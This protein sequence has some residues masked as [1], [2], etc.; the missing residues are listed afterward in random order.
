[1]TTT[2]TPPRVGRGRIVAFAVVAVLAVAGGGAYVLRNAQESQQEQT[3]AAASEAARPKLDEDAVLGVPHLVF[4][5][6]ALGPSYGKIGLVPLSDPKGPR[7]TDRGVVTKYTGQLFDKDMRPT[8]KVNIVGGPSRA[9]L[10]PDG[11]LATSTVFVAGHSYLDTGFSTVTEIVDTSTGKGRGNLEGWTT[12]KD[13]KTYKS[14]DRNFWGVT[15]ADDTTFYATVGT[16]GK[17]YLVRGDV[18]NQTMTVLRENAECPSVS[19]DGKKV[20]YKKASGPPTARKWRFTVLDLKTGVETPLPEEDSVDDQI[21]WLDEDHLIYGK[22]RDNGR[23]DVWVSPLS[24][25]KPDIL[26]PDADSPAV[27][28]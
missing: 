20:A 4:R 6:T 26:V 3:A 25:A 9:R 10:S 23:S 12:I 2:D 17:T 1:M 7:A 21:A 13:G 11:T 22:P 8:A 28:R 27:V 24:G 5:N 16:K 18:L 14:A 19:P 15:F